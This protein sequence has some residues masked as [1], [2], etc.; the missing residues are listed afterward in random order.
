MDSRFQGLRN[1]LEELQE[2]LLASQVSGDPK[3]RSTTT[4]TTILKRTQQSVTQ[5]CNKTY[6][7]RENEAPAVKKQPRFQTA[8]NLSK[9]TL[10]ISAASG[11]AATV[12]GLLA[13]L[14]D[15]EHRHIAE[16]AAMQLQI[17]KDKRRAQAA[18]ATARRAEDQRDY[19]VGEVRHLKAALQR[20][21]D[22]ITSLQ[23]QVRELEVGVACAEAVQLAEGKRYR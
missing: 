8:I 11:D 3:G 1:R 21:D 4:T 23:D 7:S 14:R 5:K 15:E 20:R 19:R 17:Q 22:V 10:N 12:G 2:Q 18:E 16:R 6:K 13:R 9:S